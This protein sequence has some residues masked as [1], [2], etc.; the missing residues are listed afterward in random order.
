L[1]AVPDGEKA[2]R[3]FAEDD[4]APPPGVGRTRMRRGKKEAV[5]R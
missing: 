2:A 4:A 1:A 3:L 5:P